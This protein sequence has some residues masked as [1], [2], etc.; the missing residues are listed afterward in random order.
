[1]TSPAASSA[2]GFG[3]CLN[4]TPLVPRIGCW[5]SAA[6]GGRSALHWALSSAKWS[7]STFPSGRSPRA[8][9][10]WTFQAS[11]MSSFA[12]AMHGTPVFRSAS[13]DSVVAADLFEHLYP[14]DSE[15]VALEAFRV[16]KPGGSFSVWTPCRTHILEVLKNNDIVLK[17][18]ISHVDY[19][20]MPRM[21]GILAS[22][23]FE[24]ARAHFAE[25]HLPGLNVAERLLQRWVP[26]LRRRIAV[27]AAKPGEALSPYM[28]A[29]EKQPVTRN[30]SA[31]SSGGAAFPWSGLKARGGE[32]YRPASETREK[33]HHQERSQPGYCLADAL[34]A[35]WPLRGQ[36]PRPRVQAGNPLVVRWAETGAHECS[37]SGDR[38]RGCPIGEVLRQG[39]PTVHEPVRSC[40]A[41]GDG[42]HAQARAHP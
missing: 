33:R 10:A 17:R 15:A 40:G 4:S 36:G 1:M 13:F 41:W 39:T 25:S 12:A 42:A 35:V 32:P 2:T 37:F 38:V 16:L 26:L 23:G 6:D 5:T 31:E 22:A 3:K 21:K 20:S 14:D 29:L 7:D 19:K 18:D 8:R 9:R 11:T 30:E 27:L 34:A 28:Q 24:I